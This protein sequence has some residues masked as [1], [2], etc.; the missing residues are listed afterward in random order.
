MIWVVHHLAVHGK[1]MVT[2]TAGDVESPAIHITDMLRRAANR[3]WQAFSPPRLQAT[4]MAVSPGSP[5]AGASVD[6]LSSHGSTVCRQRVRES[7]AAPGGRCCQGAGFRPRIEGGRHRRS[8]CHY[9]AAR[10]SSRCTST[11]CRRIRR[12]RPPL[13]SVVAALVPLSV[14]CF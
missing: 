12:P 9:G 2:R 10:R 3:D 11:T 13:R 1:R 4:S 8:E 6:A 14:W 5:T 7:M